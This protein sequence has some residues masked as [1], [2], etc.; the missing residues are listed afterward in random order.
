MSET[1]ARPDNLRAYVEATRPAKEG[2]ATEIESAR[3]ALNSFILS[4]PFPI[5][6][7]NLFS[8]VLPGVA[9]GMEESATFVDLVREAL[10]AADRHDGVASMPTVDFNA[11]ISKLAAAANI[12]YEA[13]RTAEPP[14]PVDPPQVGAVPASSGYVDDPVN[15]ATGHFLDDRVEFLMPPRV[16]SL[17]WPR[18]YSSRILSSNALGRGW[19]T[20][21]D[22]QI[23]GEGEDAV[24]IT[25][26]GRH[27][28]LRGM[29]EGEP[30]AVFEGCG[31]VMRTEG[32][33]TV[34]WG[35][36]S[37]YGLE[38]WHFDELGRLLERNGWRGGSTTFRHDDGRL[39]RITHASGRNLNVEWRNGRIA[40]VTTDDGRAATYTYNEVGDLTAVATPSGRWSYEVD[41]R[42]RIMEVTDADGVVE[43]INWYDEDGRV[44]RQANPGGRVSTFEYG[45]DRTTRVLDATGSLV[46]RYEHDEAGRLVRLVTPE[47]SRLERAFGP[48]GTTTALR[49]HDG[50]G[51]TTEGDSGPGGCLLVTHLDG[52]REEFTYDALGRVSTWQ[53]VDGPLTRFGYDGRS[54][55]PSE[56]VVEGLG[57]WRAERSADGV[58]TGT[59]D[60]DEVRIDFETDLEGFTRSVTDSAGRRTVMEPHPT[61]L[62]A[63]ITDPAGK[64]TEFGYDPAGRL[65]SVTREGVQE[66][67]ITYTEAGRPKDLTDASG[68]M[69]SVDYDTDGFASTI[70]DQCGAN[71]N[72]TRDTWGR[73][74]SVALPDGSTWTLGHTRL[75]DLAS[76]TAPSGARW[77]NEFDASNRPTRTVDPCG[78]TTVIDLD[79]AGRPVARSARTIDS[80]TFDANGRLESANSG[81]CRTTYTWNPHGR[82]ES[83]TDGDGVTTRWEWTPGGRL[84]GVHGN[85]GNVDHTYDATGLCVATATETGTWQ[86]RHDGAGRV[87]ERESPAG[88]VHRLGWDHLSRLVT[89]QGPLGTTSFTYDELD[90]IVG[91]DLGGRSTTFEYDP[92]G[93][94]TAL[95]APGGARSS[96]GYDVCGRATTRTDPLGGIARNAWDHDG[97]LVARTDQL[98][99]T[100]RF[101]H[102]PSGAVVATTDDDGNVVRYRY[103]DRSNLIAIGNQDT[104]L[105]E[106]RHSANGYLTQID[107]P[108]RGRTTTFETTPGGRLAG[109]S[110][111]AGTVTLRYE[112][113][114]LVERS[115]GDL[116]AAHWHDDPSSRSGEIDGRALELR[117]DG[118]G[119]TVHVRWGE[120]HI[121]VGRDLHGRISDVTRDDGVAV[122][123]QRDE[124]GRVEEIS[125]SDGTVRFAYDDAGRLAA[126]DTGDTTYTWGYDV[127]GRPISESS[128]SRQVEYRYDAAHQLVERL[129]DG[130]TDT[131][132]VYDAAGRRVREI[133]ARR[134]R[135]FEWDALGRLAAIVD[136]GERTVVDIDA[137][138]LLR[139][140]GD[141]RVSWDLS[142]STP[143]PAAVDGQAVLSLGR[144]LL[145]VGDDLL[146]HGLVGPHSLAPWGHAEDRA[147]VQVDV[148]VAGGLGFCGLI[149]L[150]ARIY[151][152]ATHQFLSPDP[153]G[154][155]PTDNAH[156]HPYAYVD[157]D[158]LNRW[159]PTGLSGQPISIDDFNKAREAATEGNWKGVVIAVAATALTVA[160]TATMGPVGTI[161]VSAA[162]SAGASGLTTAVYGGSTSQI[163]TSALIGGVVGAAGGGMA[164]RFGGTQTG[165]IY[166]GGETLF[167]RA[168][169]RTATPRL[170]EFALDTAGVAA[171]SFGGEGLDSWLNDHPYNVGAAVTGTGIGVAGNM[172]TNAITSR[173]APPTATPDVPVPVTSG[174]STQLPSLDLAP[175]TQSPAA[176]APAPT[177]FQGRLYVPNASGNLLVPAGSTSAT[178]M[179]PV[180]ITGTTSFGGMS[181]QPHSSGLWIPAP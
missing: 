91:H 117:A 158:P 85:A 16:Q 35:I 143:V 126:A 106:F 42:G 137:L 11:A 167:S 89:D 151:D 113:G 6:P 172:A 33:W 22:V 112:D 88:R 92:V 136:D 141:S 45:G 163:V 75:G 40:S 93:R 68:H 100:T 27:A 123:L 21:A 32:G 155:L 4:N 65:V 23:R 57:R 162:I 55:E 142:S 127:A 173:L 144:R 164:A 157:N 24:L 87:V 116:P 17:A 109:W 174:V 181:F 79:G 76:V 95:T 8:Q 86:Y 146:P 169:A 29:T 72:F 150:G 83:A 149:W 120:S 115:G 43:C 140:V 26:E 90:R 34:S 60:P 176:H 80:Q 133:T 110:D 77:A 132:Y 101:S 166:R 20:W 38:T 154:G 67:L 49:A 175:P 178:P 59:I 62:P 138:G 124:H 15:T 58:L 31:E 52:R 19:F 12:D 118:D 105:L 125:D 159:D 78:R 28:P 171:T 69:V 3:S 170:T 148:G 50:T 10:L 147:E 9:G 53:P 14:V 46:A 56:T 165:F 30:L 168:A 103:D 84:A 61:G 25:D 37:S 81:D 128:P 54:E 98:E 97:R 119:A 161:L 99:R 41:A 107:E 102:D 70:T 94:L 153:L 122:R 135:E 177:A 108:L 71:T 114:R 145:A 7:G 39:R 152:P 130:E 64:L 18:R 156:A 139:R 13:L 121:E 5:L 44:L 96:F 131:T 82:L 47:G 2:L 48:R 36:D 129:V 63:S 179:V 104:T 66:A 160:A 74:D 1:S 180:R 134:T 111:E 73:V 51:F